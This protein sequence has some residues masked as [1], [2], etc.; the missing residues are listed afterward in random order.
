MKCVFDASDKALCI[1]CSRRGSQC[2]GQE[3][4]EEVSLAAESTHPSRRRRRFDALTPV[5]LESET[6]PELEYYSTSRV[7]LLLCVQIPALC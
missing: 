3:L 2:I 6:Y 7:S 5:S 1:G 4:P